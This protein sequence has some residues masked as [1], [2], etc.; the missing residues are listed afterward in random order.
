[1]RWSIVALIGLGL[2]AAFSAALLMTTLTR[3]PETKHA[4]GNSDN[5]PV[6]V[7]VAKEDLA[8][9]MRLREEH[10]QEQ[11]VP[12]HEAPADCLSNKLQIVGQVLTRPMVKGQ[13]FTQTCFAGKTIGHDLV[14]SLKPGKRAVSVSL[15]DYAG[16]EGLLYPGSVVDVLASFQLKNRLDGALQGN[17]V[18]TTLLQGVEVLA[19]D[20]QT[21]ESI[22]E[23][24]DSSN[25]SS[26]KSMLG[27]S[28]P[29]RV[30]LLVD[31]RQA[32]ALQLAVEHGTVSLAMRNPLDASK[33]DRDATLLSGGR[34]ASLAEFLL[35]SVDD[36][37]HLQ[38]AVE[39]VNAAPP[40]VPVSANAVGSVAPPVVEPIAPPAVRQMNWDVL[41]VRGVKTEVRSFN[42]QN[43]DHNS[44]LARQDKS[45]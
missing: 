35:P 8:S 19:I 15:V 32:E 38:P 9:V 11:T 13:P 36:A 31:S 30:T 7:L 2:I 18:S 39:P 23:K 24:S 12:A 43:D 20:N 5:K 33:I 10:I 16:M 4:T 21:V 41:I 14:A 3:Q 29:R 6:T 26:S 25:S 44:V 40:V 45:R 28:R 42:Y 34:L 37:A 17:A 1:M 27:K 22:S